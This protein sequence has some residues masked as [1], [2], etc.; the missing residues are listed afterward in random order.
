MPAA[1]ATECDKQKS[2]ALTHS[3]QGVEKPTNQLC[4]VPVANLRE[5]RAPIPSV[6]AV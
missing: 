1:A 2:M 5:G 3:R 4:Q 6:A